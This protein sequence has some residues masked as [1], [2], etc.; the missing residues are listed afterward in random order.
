MSQPSG[1][2]TLTCRY[3]GKRY[4]RTNWMRRHGS[5]LGPDGLLLSDT[6]LIGC[7]KKGKPCRCVAAEKRA[8]AAE[9]EV[10]RLWGTL[11]QLSDKLVKAD[12]ENERL[13]AE[14][15]KLEGIVAHLMRTP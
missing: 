13:R 7:V 15:R 12:E 8:A 1:T 14:N 9:A 10:E 5:K 11:N 6:H 3:C 4:R 2:R